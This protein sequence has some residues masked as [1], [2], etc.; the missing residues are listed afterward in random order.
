M[1]AFFKRDISSWMDGTEGLSDGAYR[2]YDVICQRIIMLGG[3]ISLNE[4]AIA[5]TCNQRV[6]RFRRH[7][8]EL[9]DCKK[10]WLEGERLSA[11]LSFIAQPDAPIPPNVRRLVLNRDGN[12]CRYCG[13]GEN[14][15][16]D[17]IRPHSRGGS[18][19]PENLCTACRC[20]NISKSD[21]TPSEW[22]Q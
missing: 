9:L 5:G 1:V 13:S 4:R 2:A 10:V 7:L 8:Q 3:P 6:D 20:C 19:E 16:L 11:D 21:R 15:Q 12:A 17:H 14:L 18:D 22:L